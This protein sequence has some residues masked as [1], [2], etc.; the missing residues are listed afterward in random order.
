[1]RLFL[2]TSVLIA[3]SGSSQGA[4]RE[5]FRLALDQGWSL[6]ATPYVIEEVL[7]NIGDLLPVASAEWAKLR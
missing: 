6:I 2:D 3:A 4:S 1:M 7:S 5:I